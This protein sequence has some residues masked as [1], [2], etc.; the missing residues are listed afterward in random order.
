MNELSPEGS[1][2]GLTS[3]HTLFL[4]MGQKPDCGLFATRQML[5]QGLLSKTNSV[6][7][8]SHAVDEVAARCAVTGIEVQ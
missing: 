4:E 8:W 6:M 2:S 1:M 3:R 5:Y 7:P